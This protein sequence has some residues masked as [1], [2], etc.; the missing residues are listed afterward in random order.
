LTESQIGYLAFLN[1]DETVLTMYAWSKSAMEEC[2]ISDKPIIY[3]VETTGLW[4]EAVRQRRPIITNDYQEPNSWKKGYPQGHVHVTRHMN[5]PVF[6]GERIVLVAGVGN[7]P[8]HYNESDVNQLT[9]LME[10]MWKIIQRQRAEEEI[11]KLNEELEQR[12]ID[13][14]AELEAANKELRHSVTLSRTTCAPLRHLAV[15][16][17]Y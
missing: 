8:G 11:H 5:V 7:K 1:E 9:L 4:G 17:N 6:E 2:R 15:L 13:R 14:T 10:G 3:P 12:V 16:L